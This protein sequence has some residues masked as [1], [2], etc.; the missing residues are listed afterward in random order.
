[1]KKI[2]TFGFAMVAT[3]LIFS[4][5]TTLTEDEYYTNAKQAYTKNNFQEA[6]KNFNLLVSN[7]PDGNKCAEAYF[8]LGFINANDIKNLSEAE[9]YYKA[10]IEKFPNHDLTDDAQYELENL[11]KD[12]N[13]LP[14]FKNL[15]ADSTES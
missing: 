14:M 5:S 7:Y 15:G 11:G 8:M 1:M 10:F 13:D 6:L 9:K 2:Y 12:I 4:C 3:I